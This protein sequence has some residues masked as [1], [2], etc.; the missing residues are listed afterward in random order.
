MY[1]RRLFESDVQH[2]YLPGARRG[3]LNWQAAKRCA[4]NG[5]ELMLCESVLDAVSL[6]VAGVHDVVPCYG[7]GGF[8]QDHTAILD[9]FE[10]TKVGLCFDGDGIGAKA[11]QE[12]AA[13]VQQHRRGAAVRIVTLPTDTDPNSILVSRGAEALQHLVAQGRD[14]PQPPFDAAPASTISKGAE[15]SNADATDCAS[16]PTEPPRPAFEK[17]RQG[18]ILHVEDRRYEAKAI[19]RQSTQLR[20]TIKASKTSSNDD[21]FELSTIDIY[22]HRSRDWFAG[23]CANLFDVDPEHTRADMRAIVEHTERVTSGADEADGEA[24]AAEAPG[25]HRAGPARL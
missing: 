19:A 14:D 16:G 6:Y 9:R 11:S 24:G 2:L 21:R 22:S 15:A 13:K 3:L 5:G 25:P 7:A 12:L 17:T 20:V 23:V 1:G 10:V 4:H 8:T 18:Y